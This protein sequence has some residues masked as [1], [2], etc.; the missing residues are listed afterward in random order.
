MSATNSPTATEEGLSAQ[1]F[2]ANSPVADVF[3]EGLQAQMPVTNS[4]TAT[5]LEEGLSAQISDANSP[6][7]VVAENPSTAIVP[8]SEAVNNTGVPTYSNTEVDVPLEFDSTE[9]IADEL[10]PPSSHYESDSISLPVRGEEV[11]AS[12]VDNTLPVSA[13]TS[14]SRIVAP[15]INTHPRLQEAKQTANTYFFVDQ[16]WNGFCVMYPDMCFFK[17]WHAGG[18][19]STFGV[20]SVEGNSAS[21]ASAAAKI[22]IGPSDLDCMWTC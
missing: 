9:N 17:V 19:S 12:H 13:T 3:E 21:G 7:A 20:V 10:S 5:A 4:P 2:D 6:V 11:V 15:T 14:V 1:M 18:S 8:V 16:K 22:S